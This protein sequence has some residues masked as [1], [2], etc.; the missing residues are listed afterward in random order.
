[1]QLTQTQLA[2]M[3]HRDLA[4]VDCVIIHHSV[5][6]QTMDIADVAAEEEAD[7]HFI[8]VGYHAYV[9]LV[10]EAHDLWAVQI[11]RP[12]EDVPA[13]ALGYNTRSIDICIGGNYE[14]NV[15]NIATNNVSENA[16]QAAIGW[17]TGAKTKL[18][19]LKYLAGHRDVATWTEILAAEG[20]TPADVSTACP[21]QILYD[22]LH[23]LRV[24][25]GLATRPT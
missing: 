10:D 17:I 4:V 21:G 18:P 19:N 1:M 14:P 11:G 13:A 23:D 22:R 5:G 25:T 24:A 16:L 8:T 20:E 2:D 12:I 15:P 6:A 9:K 3:N 7:Q